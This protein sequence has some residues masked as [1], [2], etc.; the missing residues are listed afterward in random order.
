M[1]RKV[2]TKAAEVVEDVKLKEVVPVSAAVRAAVSRAMTRAASAVNPYTWTT[3]EVITADKLNA[4]EKTAA[5]AHALAETNE[6]DIGSVQG[7][8]DAVTETKDGSH[9]VK[10]AAVDIGN[11][12]AVNAQ[13]GMLEVP[14]DSE[15]MQYSGAGIGVKDGGITAGK[16]AAEA[17][18]GGSIA[19]GSIAGPHIKECYEVSPDSMSFETPVLTAIRPS[20]NQAYSF[21]TTSLTVESILQF[22]VPYLSGLGGWLT[23][24]MIGDAAVHGMALAMA[25]AAP[26]GSTEPGDALGGVAT[27]PGKANVRPMT[28]GLSYVSTFQNGVMF[29]EDMTATVKGCAKPD[30]ATVTVSNGVLS[31]VQSQTETMELQEGTVVD[32]FAGLRVSD[33][34]SLGGDLVEGVFLLANGTAE[35]IAIPAETVFVTGLALRDSAAQYSAFDVKAGWEPLTVEVNATG[36][37]LNFTTAVTVKANST[38][39]VY[40]VSNSMTAS[41]RIALAEERAKAGED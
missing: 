2:K 21:F 35:D 33:L 36:K 17:V 31:A 6:Q 13:T 29:I 30:N 37:S 28:S 38:M 41:E 8:V 18:T 14:V 7:V 9:K 25:A 12:L 16:L 24:D 3:G 23:R 5:D 22:T 4:L 40:V 20:D 32:T 39:P 1:A 27:Y 15:T 26:A 10:G 11:G 34:R 19:A